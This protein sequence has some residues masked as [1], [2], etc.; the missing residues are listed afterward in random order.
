V[1]KVAIGI[2]HLAEVVV[3]IYSPLFRLVKRIIFAIYSPI[4][5]GPEDSRA[6]GN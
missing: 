6:L 2:E 3:E 5:T 4:R 1:E